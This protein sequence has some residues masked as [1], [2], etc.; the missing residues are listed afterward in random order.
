MM[1]EKSNLINL[2]KASLE[3]TEQIRTYQ[4]GIKANFS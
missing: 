4:F 1:S 2:D 3:K